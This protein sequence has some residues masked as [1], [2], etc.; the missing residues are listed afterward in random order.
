MIDSVAT[1]L[2]TE[3]GHLDLR[4]SDP[5]PFNASSVASGVETALKG[6]GVT[7]KAVNPAIVR[8]EMPVAMRD[9]TT[10]MQLVKLA[11]EVR[12]AVENPCKVVID[13]ANG[14][15]IAGEGVLISPCLV[16]VEDLTIAIV[17]E[18]FV[19]QPN[20]FSDGTSERV[21]RTRVE[22]QRNASELGALGGGGATVTDLMQN[23]KA[24]GL[25]PH[26]LIN[27]FTMLKMS[28]FLH[29]DLEVR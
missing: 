21:G 12:V 13:Q 17:E 11:G 29:A 19:S 9:D 20:P 10:A 26:Q 7:V 15:L 4:L 5:S 27:V 16:T 1:S 24:L 8:I 25:K 18:E 3:S 28:G 23:L 2:L 14:T 22:V 6:T